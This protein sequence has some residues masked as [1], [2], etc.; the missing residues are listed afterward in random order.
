MN[1]KLKIIMILLTKKTWFYVILFI[2]LLSPAVLRAQG[3]IAVDISPENPQ[4]GEKVTL[5]L[6]SFLSNLDQTQISWIKDGKTKLSGVG[7]TTFVFIAND[8]GESTTVEVVV[9]L[10]TG[11]EIHRT[12]IVTPQNVDLLW[13]ASDSFVPSFYRGKALPASEAKIKV[14]AMP[15]VE[16]NG[17]RLKPES[18]TYDWQ[19]DL[20]PVTSASGYAKSSYTFTHNVF[21][22]SERI[23]VEVSPLGGGVRASGNVFIRPFIPKILFYENH[24]LEGINYKRALNRGFDMRSAE[25]TI[26]AAPYFFSPKNIKGPDLKYSWSINNEPI[27]TPENKNSLFLILEEGQ[28]GTARIS[29]SIESISKLFL[30][31][32]A[33]MAIN[34]G[35]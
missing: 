34:L 13:E 22:E 3:G 33:D 17:T 18:L 7:E 31:A 29:L 30:S 16:S 23:D 27:A 15:V 1:W 28:R 12:I 8:P 21:R 19:R 10:T 25:V 11:T 20:D 26:V 4:S 5:R 6:S 14:V 32:D 9:I 24:P 35:G 2:F